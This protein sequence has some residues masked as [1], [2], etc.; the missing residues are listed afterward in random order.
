ME[1]VSEE[2]MEQEFQ[3]GHFPLGG[4]TRIL[5]LRAFRLRLC[6]KNQYHKSGTVHSLETCTP[7]TWDNLIMSFAFAVEK[8]AYTATTCAALVTFNLDSLYLIR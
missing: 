6:D 4:A 7:R 8:A 1:I 5:L 2:G 3:W